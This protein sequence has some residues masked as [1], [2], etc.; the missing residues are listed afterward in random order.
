MMSNN[1][2]NCPICEGRPQGLSFP[3]ETYFNAVKFK[4]L[5]CVGCK[6]V[7]VDPVP[8]DQTFE[9]MYEKVNY[10]D[11]FYEGCEVEGFKESVSLLRQYVKEGSEVLD[12]G[13]GVGG[14]LKACA[15]QGLAPFGVEF[16][17]EAALL[18][19]KNASCD[20]IS[21][22]SF[23]KLTCTSRYDAIHM[24]D[25]LE[26]LPDPLSTVSRLIDFLKPG[27]V[28]FIEGPI[29]INPSPVYLA[30]K[31]FGATKRV[32]N[33][34]F[35]SN[36]P[37]THLVRTSAQSQRK[38][39]THFDKMLTMRCWQVYETGWPYNNG[40]LI[41]RS[42]SVISE[43]IGGCQFAGVTFGNRFKVILLKT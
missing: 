6:S 24:G 18:A 35:V 28:L 22:E 40:G 42:I 19:G 25:V 17:R 16:D 30:T 3:Y 33:P 9:L 14:F 41:K 34:T 2:R 38:F 10:H 15:A 21:V 13:C 27:G 12:Y 37:P 32:F 39:F 7:F 23:N 11:R 26:H 1:Y 31:I 4:Y 29:E 8:D 36:D 20:V 43:I 5:K